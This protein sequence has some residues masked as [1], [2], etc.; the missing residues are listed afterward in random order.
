MSVDAMSIAK[1]YAK[2]I[3][4]IAKA[5]Q[6]IEQWQQILAALAQLIQSDLIQSVLYLPSI[7][8]KTL[9]AIIKKALPSMVDAQADRFLA[10]LARHKR[11]AYL[12]QIFEQYERIKRRH[13]NATAVVVY[14]P[15]ALSDTLK[16]YV[17]QR[18][19][20]KLQSNAMLEYVVDPSLI[21]GVL[22][23]IHDKIIDRSMRNAFCQMRQQLRV[24][25]AS[26]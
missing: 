10:L 19:D 24:G 11:M 9:V 23:Q 12:P 4:D 16:Q 8:Q 3:Y 1:P 5:G 13:E 17:Q 20:D 21:G 2:A 6:S 7:D 25:I 14:T 22:L 26:I 15:V 18:L